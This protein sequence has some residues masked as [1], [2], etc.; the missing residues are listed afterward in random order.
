MSNVTVP[1]SPEDR[2]KILGAIKEISDSLT[3]IESERDLIKDILSDIEDKF[4]L[5][6]K[7]TRKVAKIYHK[8]NM[9][10]VKAEQEEL[11]TIYETVTKV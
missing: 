2:K 9:N 8:Q 1:S 6:K 5:P 7:Y 10:E 4:E 11:E 3:R